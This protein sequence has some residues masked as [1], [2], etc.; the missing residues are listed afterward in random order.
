MSDELRWRKSSRSGSQG[1]ACVE[2]A[3]SDGAWYVRD[4]KSPDGGRLVIDQVAWRSFVGAIRR[5]TL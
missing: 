1:G 2:V 3:A 4:S 5:R